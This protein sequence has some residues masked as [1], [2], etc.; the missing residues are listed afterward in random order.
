MKQ[1]TAVI[2]ELAQDSKQ[3]VRISLKKIKVIKGD[4]DQSVLTHLNE[5]ILIISKSKLEL[6]CDWTELK[7]GG[8]ICFVTEDQPAMTRSIPPQ[9]LDCSVIRVEKV[10]GETENKQEERGNTMEIIKKINQR[11]LTQL[12]EIW[13]ETNIDAHNFI[14]A[15]YWKSKYQEVENL[16]PQATLFIYREDSSQEITGF[17]GLM[18]DYIAGIFVRKAY[19]RKGIGKKLLLA[20]KTER[21]CLKLYVYEKNQE[22]YQFYIDQGFTE[23]N[24]SIDEETAEEEI[25][26][27]WYK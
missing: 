4:T 21:E 6:A 1:F 5:L 11:D 20:A 23:V 25:A 10:K 3:G 8:S 12:L 19:Q 9:L 13:L 2:N 24:K 14:D 7:K 18:D 22:A 15:S 17:L 26:M 27:I 16:L